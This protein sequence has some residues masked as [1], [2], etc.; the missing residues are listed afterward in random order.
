MI[1]KSSK[2]VGHHLFMIPKSI[3]LQSHI[4]FYKLETPQFLDSPLKTLVSNMKPQKLKMDINVMQ[5]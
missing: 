4:V 5:A 3:D 2:I 1:H